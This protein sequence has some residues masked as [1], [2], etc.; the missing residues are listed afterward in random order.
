MRRIGELMANLGFNKDAPESTQKAF[1]KHLI[2]AANVSQFQ[3]KSKPIET[4]PEQL[5]FDFEDKTES[6]KADAT[7]ISSPLSKSVG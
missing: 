3:R 7:E 2:N 6:P 5:C 4:S 1:I